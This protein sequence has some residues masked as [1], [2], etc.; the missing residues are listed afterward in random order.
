MPSSSSSSSSTRV[1]VR[2]TTVLAFLQKQS[3]SLTRIGKLYRQLD[4]C[5]IT[6]KL[7]SIC[8]HFHGEATVPAAA[9][10]R[11]LDK[12]RQG[13]AYNNLN[14]FFSLLQTHSNL[15]TQGRQRQLLKR[16][17]MATREL[18]QFMELCSFIDLKVKTL[19]SY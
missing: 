10:T 16:R 8:R 13:K 7:K 1:G 6:N 5:T 19:S 14:V 9:W 17:C 12:A 18:F 11:V 3:R 2:T 15:A 4:Y